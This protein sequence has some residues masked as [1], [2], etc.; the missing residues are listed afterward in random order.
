MDQNLLADIIRKTK[1]AGA[2]DV[3]VLAIDGTSVNVGWR[4]GKIENLER[5]EGQDLGIRA[6]VGKRQAIVSTTDTAPEN[7]DTMIARVVEMAKI[8]PE[9]PH[10]GL[11]D[12]NDVATSIPALD[13]FDP[14]EPDVEQLKDMAHKAEQAALE[15]KGITNSEG[16]ETGWHQTSVHFMASNGVNASYK[17]SGS[18]LSVSVL[19]GKGV[20]MERDYDFTDQI[21][22]SDLADPVTVGKSAA[23]RTLKRLNPKRVGTQNVPVVYDPRV[24]K[25]LLG[26]FA[27][28]INGATIARGTSFLKHDLGKEIFAKNITIIDDPHLP[29]GQRSKPID[30]E[31][32]ATTKRVFVENGI[33]QS[34]VLDTRTARQLG[35]KSTGHAKRDVL[36]PP[37]PS[38]TNLYMQ[39]GNLPPKELIADIKSGFYVTDTMGMGVSIVTGDYSQGASGFWIENGEIAYPVSEVTIAGNL[40]DMFAHL[41]P[42]NDLQLIY[43]FNVPTL[44]VENMTVAGQ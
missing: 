7:I 12:T 28:A 21:Y 26:N 25:S 2:T 30:V 9:D 33:L 14:F 10:V 18:F 31:G 22:F 3:D 5:E 34:W 19:G 20:N 11:A 35:L 6:L 44:R 16:A 13:I 41:T 43:G 17:R 15:V 36:S 42:A 4:L 38:A 24:G 40:R 39:P 32:I 29:R 1:K 37:S 23:D 8:A 27:S